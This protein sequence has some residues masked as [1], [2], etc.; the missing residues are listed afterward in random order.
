M[1]Q[2]RKKIWYR[3]ENKEKVTQQCVVDAYL[4]IENRGVEGI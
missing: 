1:T 4:K 2:E 3:K